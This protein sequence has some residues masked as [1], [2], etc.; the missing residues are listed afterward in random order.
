MELEVLLIVRQQPLLHGIL[1]DFAVVSTF[2][3]DFHDAGD[4]AHLF[5]VIQ[6]GTSDAGRFTTIRK[7]RFE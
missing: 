2:A 1:G 5:V 4:G 3:Q 6:H 7:R